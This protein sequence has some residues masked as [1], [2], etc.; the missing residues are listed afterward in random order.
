MASNGISPKKSPAV[1][2][3]RFIKTPKAYALGGLIL[4]TLLGSLTPGGAHALPH[5][6]MAVAVAIIVDGLVAALFG[7]KIPFSVGGIITALIVS[8]VMSS[9]TSGLFIVLT[10]VVAVASKH[11]LKQGRKPVFNPAAVGLLVAALLFGSAESWWASMPDTPIWYLL[12]LL[13]VGVFVSVRVK[14][15]VQVLTFLGS[16]FVLILVMALMHWG[17]PSATPADALRA[18]FVNAALFLGFFMLTDPP[19]SPGTMGQQ[20]AF[21]VIAALV[22]VLVFDT[23]GGL[24]Y[25]LIGLLSANGWTAWRSRARKSREVALAKAS[26]KNRVAQSQ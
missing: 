2:F 17:L 19:T 4:L 23:M 10:T 25:P 22:A 13:A 1:L 14:K 15:Y 9:L 8:D 6:A 20:V 16:Y 24:V 12:I 5:A 18:P 26:P 11:V 7:R 3:R 21:S